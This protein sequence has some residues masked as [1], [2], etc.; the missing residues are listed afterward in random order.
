MKK[1]TA[2]GMG[3]LLT[4]GTSG[5]LAG[6][7]GAETVTTPA[8][9]ATASGSGLHIP[10]VLSVGTTGAG[11]DGADAASG[12]VVV[13]LLGQPLIGGGQAGTGHTE[14]A[15]IDTGETPLGQL[16]VAPWEATAAS[17][18]SARAAEAKAAVAR[19]D[20]ISPDLLHVDL[21]QSQSGVAHTDPLSAGASS[22]DAAVIRFGS[23]TLKV[24]HA[25]TDMHGVARTWLLDVNGM[26]IGE[27]V[28]SGC[29]A[30]LAP[31]A[32]AG[33]QVSGGGAAGATIAD[34]VGDDV[35]SLITGTTGPLV[36]AFSAAA[37]GGTGTTATGS[38]GAPVVEGQRTVGRAPGGGTATLPFTGAD[39][40]ALVAFG[41]FLCALGLVV[42]NAPQLTPAPAVIRRH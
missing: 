38:G 42:V 31:V 13:S 35:A 27:T 4:I 25:E 24:L 9:P 37:G 1:R 32:A 14:D 2:V 36:R 34:V 19:A 8:P 11:A 41:L 17:G 16:E 30:D 28:G 29:L 20:V 39:V 22:S 3:V 33:C 7:A 40:L 18:D 6:T 23:L 21:I 12:A 15:L 26:K 5:A 10:G